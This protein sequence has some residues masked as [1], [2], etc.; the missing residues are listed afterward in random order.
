MLRYQ[1][2]GSAKEPYQITAVGAGAD[3]KIYCTCPAGRRGGLFCKHIAALL[4]GDVTNVVLPSDDVEE[5][6]NNA[7]GSS[8]QSKALLHISVDEKRPVIN[9]YFTLDQ[10]ER[11]YRPCIESKGWM[12]TRRS[13]QE[14]GD[15]EYIELFKKT[16]SGKWRKNPSISLSYHSTT[17]DIITDND[18]SLTYKNPR[19]RGRPWCVRADGKSTRTW[20]NLAGAL[21]VFLDIIGVDSNTQ[22]GLNIRLS[23]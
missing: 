18:G 11:D 14:H 10:V 2:K 15:E 19:P 9:G 22:G 1:V 23:L 7:Q 5:L 8:Y 3:M 13:S 16:R 21:P 6:I 17:Y 4:M 20:A 12:F